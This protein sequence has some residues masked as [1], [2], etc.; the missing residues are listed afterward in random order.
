MSRILYKKVVVVVVNVEYIACIKNIVTKVTGSK[1]LSF[2]IQL[3]ERDKYPNN[4][5][6]TLK[7]TLK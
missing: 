2:D 5:I 4:A 6:T 1:L 7:A 3:A